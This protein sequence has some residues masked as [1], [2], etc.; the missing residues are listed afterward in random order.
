MSSAI[1]PGSFDP[2]TK[3]HLDVIEQASKLFDQVYVAI[4]TN[5]AKK[6]LFNV[7]ERVKLAQDALQNV[8]NVVVVKSPDQLTIE[9]AREL[10]AKAIIRGVRN[11]ADF[12]YEQQI[13]AMNQQMANDIETV[14]FFTKPENSFVAS[15]I[16]KEV[17]KFNGDISSFLPENVALALAE[18]LG[19]NNE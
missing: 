17:A 2:I 10:G 3:G 18:K 12:L 19:K 8:N 16:I 4:M 6:Y 11:S 1:F 15:S 5:T 14:L 13:A 7:D 9:V